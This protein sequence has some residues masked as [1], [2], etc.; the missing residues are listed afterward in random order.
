MLKRIENNSKFHSCSLIQ[1]LLIFLLS[2]RKS[3]STFKYMPFVFTNLINLSRM[4]MA[5]GRTNNS[6]KI[7][8]CVEWIGVLITAWA[9]AKKEEKTSGRGELTKEDLEIDMSSGDTFPG[10]N[11]AFLKLSTRPPLATVFRSRETQSRKESHKRDW[12]TRMTSRKYLR[13]WSPTIEFRA[14][15]RI[16]TFEKLTSVWRLGSLTRDRKPADALFSTGFWR[17]S[18]SFPFVSTI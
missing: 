13:F 3:S 14:G 6:S 5:Y 18:F 4:I 16:N 17:S 11:R 2:H 8:D 12:E 9:N 7:A 10:I 1:S 15:K